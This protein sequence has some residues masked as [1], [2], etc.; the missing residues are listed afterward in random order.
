MRFFPTQQKGSVLILFAITIPLLFLFSAIAFELGAVYIQR[1]H[2]QNIADA[3]ALAGAKS[4]NGT[5]N[6][7]DARNQASLYISQN[8]SDSDTAAGQTT[9]ITHPYKNDLQKIQVTLAEDIPLYFF[10][11]FGY[12]S[13]HLSVSAVA[14]NSGSAKGLFDYGIISGSSSGVL[15]LG[16]G[17]SN[18]YNAN[19]YSNYKIS[20][21]G[22][23]NTVNGTIST[24]S[25]SAWSTT[26]QNSFFGKYTLNTGVSPIDISLG[27]SG[28]SDLIQQIKAQNTYNG[29]YTGALN[30]KNFGKG[31]YVKGNFAPGYIEWT[32]DNSILNSTTIVIAE[33]DISFG[34]NNGMSMSSNNYVIYC[35]LNGNI[36]FTFNG[37]FYGILYAPKGNINLYMGGST[38]YGSIVGQTL[39][40]GYGATTINYKNYLGTGNASGKVSLIE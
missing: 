15:N 39:D 20:Q 32:S 24:V 6:D 19:L 36:T 17:G 37:P 14:S 40:L 22:G 1:A 7:T 30:L 25:N 28:L 11:Y 16:P 4:L 9:S 10:K 18:T 13:M 23:N 35:S 3:A 38:Y 31:I 2:M 21:G 26:S 27:N 33:G 12:N 8:N 34:G 5:T 29:N